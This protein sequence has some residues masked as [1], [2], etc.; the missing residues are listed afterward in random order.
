MYR[1]LYL[2]TAV[3]A[4]NFNYKI[5]IYQHAV[6]RFDPTGYY[7]VLKHFQNNLETGI[8]QLFRLVHK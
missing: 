8:I 2:Y 4:Y 3:D 7:W 1:H 6:A 5:V